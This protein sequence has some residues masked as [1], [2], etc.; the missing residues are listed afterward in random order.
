MYLWTTS[1]WNKPCYCS[2]TVVGLNQSWLTDLGHVILIKANFRVSAS[3]A[4]LLFPL[5]GFG[6]LWR[7][8]SQDERV[9]PALRWSCSGSACR[10]LAARWYTV[11]TDLHRGL[12]RK[13]PWAGKLHRTWRLQLVVINNQPLIYSPNRLSADAG[14]RLREA[15]RRRWRREG[16]KGSM[17]L[18]VCSVCC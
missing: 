15:M 8:E 1:I 17:S 4:A 6:S 16:S 12:S 7:N 2:W 9:F 10:F 11:D 18:L 3:L 13:W 14:K 5:W